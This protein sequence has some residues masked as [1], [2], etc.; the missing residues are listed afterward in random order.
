MDKPKNTVQFYLF[1][2]SAGTLFFDLL[3]DALLPVL[4]V[5]KRFS[6]TLSLEEGREGKQADVRAALSV[7]SHSASKQESQLSVCQPACL[8]VEPQVHEIAVHVST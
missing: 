4:L 2:D 1:P 7:S 6:N 8:V 5:S 3:L